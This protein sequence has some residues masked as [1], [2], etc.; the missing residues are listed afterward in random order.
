MAQASKVFVTGSSELPDQHVGFA[1]ELG[2]RLMKET[3]A[4]LVTGGLGSKGAGMRPAVDGLVARA[5][6]SAVG[7][8]VSALSRIITM[9]PES[10]ER[11]H[12]NFERVKA[13]TVIRVSYAGLRSRRYSMV[14]SSDAV[15]AI[16]GGDATREVI[17]LA[18]IAGK[19]LIPIPSTGGAALECWN[20]YKPEL[21]ARLSL[22][23]DELAWIS[24]Q[25]NSP[26]SGAVFA[27]I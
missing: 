11:D 27:P 18:Y 3:S 22:P 5:A 15:V 4:V 24:T 17:D 1:R 12:P 6:L 8:N 19:P 23:E 13:G 26:N 20:E 16:G 21:L 25:G 10:D 14:L 7:D 2:H 9:L